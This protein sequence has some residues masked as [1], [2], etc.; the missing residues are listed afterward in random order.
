VGV[1]GWSAVGFVII[2]WP[3]WSGVADAPGKVAIGAVPEPP[4]VWASRAGG[5]TIEAT[6]IQTTPSRP[7]ERR[8]RDVSSPPNVQKPRMRML[9]LSLRTGI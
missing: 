5:R 4:K 6:S 8:R 3:G 7:K 1:I 2:G 9:A